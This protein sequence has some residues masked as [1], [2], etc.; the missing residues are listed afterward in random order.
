MG[1]PRRRG[2]QLTP[3]ARDPSGLANPQRGQRAVQRRHTSMAWLAPSC[4]TTGV[5]GKSLRDLRTADR[6]LI[7]PR[8]VN[9][10]PICHHIPLD[11][12]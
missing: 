11:H 7:E 12:R 3:L 5:G 9:G 10:Q 1:V 4:V 6:S 2:P 8:R